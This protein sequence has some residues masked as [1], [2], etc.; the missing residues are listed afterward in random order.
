MCQGLRSGQEGEHGRVQ[1]DHL[2]VYISCGPHSQTTAASKQT[3]LCPR[4]GRE[5]ARM[6]CNSGLLTNILWTS[7]G[8]D[9]APKSHHSGVPSV[10]NGPKTTQVAGPPQIYQLLW[11]LWNLAAVTG[12]EM[13][14]DS[15]LWSG[16]VHNL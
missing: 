1:T 12:N 9:L 11:L 16:P 14:R 10:S 13:V 3:E 8:P 5:V 7:H 4:V 6:R 2:T 15:G